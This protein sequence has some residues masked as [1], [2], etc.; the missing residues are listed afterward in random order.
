VLR[1]ACCSGRLLESRGCAADELLQCLSDCLTA[2]TSMG[3][4]EGERYLS[5]E[6]A[7]QCTGARVGWLLCVGG[8][9]LGG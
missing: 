2:A 7:K 6:L 5:L 4:W 3:D 1:A 8:A 9:E